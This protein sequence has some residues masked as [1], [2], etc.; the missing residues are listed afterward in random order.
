MDIDEDGLDDVIFG[1]TSNE[2]PGGSVQSVE[3]MK[4][5]CA[6]KGKY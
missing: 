3:E 5:R 4:K 1:M 2:F 6:K